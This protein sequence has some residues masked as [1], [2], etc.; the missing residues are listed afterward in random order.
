[1]FPLTSLVI[2]PLESDAVTSCRLIKGWWVEEIQAMAPLRTEGGPR[3]QP[4]SISAA[5]CN[6]QEQRVQLEPRASVCFRPRDNVQRQWEGWTSTPASSP[7]QRAGNYFR[8]FEDSGL[9]RVSVLLTLSARLPLPLPRRFSASA[10]ALAGTFL[11]RA[12]RGRCAGCPWPG[13]E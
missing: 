8:C 4:H 2:Q 9:M 11:F 6:A 1:M 13:R 5:R 7:W 10:W 3:C 12:G